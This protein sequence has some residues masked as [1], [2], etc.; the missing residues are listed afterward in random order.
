[1][2]SPQPPIA[3]RPLAASAALPIRALS[4]RDRTGDST[5]AAEASG[6]SAEIPG[7]EVAADAATPEAAAPCAGGMPLPVRSESAPQV[8][9]EAETAPPV[10]LARMGGTGG[11]L[12]CV[13]LPAGRDTGGATELPALPATGD[14]PPGRR[15]ATRHR[16]EHEMC[17]TIHPPCPPPI[18]W[19]SRWKTLNGTT[20]AAGLS[21]AAVSSSGTAN[22]ITERAAEAEDRA[23]RATPPEAPA[24]ITICPA[25]S[26]DALSVEAGTQ[27]AAPIAPPTATPAQVVPA[28]PRGTVP[29]LSSRAV[30]WWG[31]GFH[32]LWITSLF[33]CETINGGGVFP[34]L[35]DALPAVSP[36]ALPVVLPVVLPVALPVALGATLPTAGPTALPAILPIALPVVGMTALMTGKPPVFSPSAPFVVVRTSSVSLASPAFSVAI[37]DSPRGTPA[38][39]AKGV[40]SPGFIAV[41]P[42]PTAHRQWHAPAPVR[43]APIKRGCDRD[44][45]HRPSPGRGGATPRHPGASHA[46]LGPDSGGP[47]ARSGPGSIAIGRQGEPGRIRVPHLRGSHRRPAVTAHRSRAAARGDDRGRT[48]DAQEPASAQTRP[49]QGGAIHSTGRAPHT[50]WRTT[51]TPPVRCGDN[52]AGSLPGHDPHRQSSAPQA[53]MRSPW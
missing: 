53:L 31:K 9:G 2:V 51:V 6:G 16:V 39:A 36:V 52:G 35:R 19:I 5:P 32:R 3:G 33:L 8:G 42:M 22:A 20:S 12:T 11:A 23:R 4:P 17:I 41:D 14:G 1:V 43:V 37:A 47:T 40:G 7:T 29:F 13:G 45:P 21:T 26:M 28:R 38:S 15:G 50:R 46:G 34:G 25:T 27:N 24:S 30:D 10:N 18:L 48:T 44:H 49:V